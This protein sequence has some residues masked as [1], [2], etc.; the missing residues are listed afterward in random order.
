MPCQTSRQHGAQLG[1]RVGD[2]CAGLD[3]AALVV[4]LVRSGDVFSGML[5]VGAGYYPD[6]PFP[7]GCGVVVH[8]LSIGGGHSGWRS[9]ALAGA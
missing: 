8:G 4:S 7:A 9:L 3:S 6:Q 1:Q 2:Q 5:G